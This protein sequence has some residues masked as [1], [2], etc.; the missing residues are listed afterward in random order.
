M[1]KYEVKMQV[2][3]YGEIE[4][5]SQAEAEDIAYSAWGTTMDSQMTYDSVEYVRAS[6]MGEIC[7]ECE[8]VEDD[9]ECNEEDEEEGEAE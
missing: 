5:E 8:Q 6:D 2:N 4:A 3:F 1:N 9:C 7:D